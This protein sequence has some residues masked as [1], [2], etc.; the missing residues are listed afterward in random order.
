MRKSTIIIP[1]AVL[2]AGCSGNSSNSYQISGTIPH[3]EDGSYVYLVNRMGEA[4]VDSALVK[5]GAFTFKGEADGSAKFLSYSLTD[6]ANLSYGQVFLESGKIAADMKKASEGRSVISGTPIN[7]AAA[8]LYSKLDALTDEEEEKYDELVLEAIDKNI[9]NPFGVNLLTSNYYSMEPAQVNEYL[10]KIPAE[11]SEGNQ[12]LEKIRST[13][14]VQ[15]ETAP[16]CQYKDFTMKTPEG[17]DISLSDYVGKNKLVLV[18]FWASWCGPCVREMPNVKKLYADFHGKGLEIVG[19]SLD[20]DEEAW[21]NGIKNLDLPWVHM[22][23]VKYWNCEGARLYGVN[24]IPATVL[25][26]K[27]GTILKRN[28][29]GEELYNTVQELLK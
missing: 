7:D 8:E 17:K 1:L 24:S 5:D 14:K 4:P 29:R 6:R 13:V 23:D 27:D 28:L 16:G 21:K 26:A 25:I 3:A 22:S 2:L 12:T 18:D 19:V 20:R 9:A 10:D 15:L 11:L